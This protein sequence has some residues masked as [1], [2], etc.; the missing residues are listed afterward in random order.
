MNRRR[1]L[2]LTAGGV[3][4]AACGGGSTDQEFA[5][6]KWFSDQTILA[7]GSPQR[8][9]WSFRDDE[10]N[11]ADQA[12]PTAEYVVLGP[13][14]DQIAS[15]TT[16][17][18]DDGVA[19]PYYPVMIAFSEPGIHEFRF[20][21]DDHGRHVGFASPGLAAD[22]TLFWPGDAFPSVPT[23][24][25]DDD[26]G[27]ADICTRTENCPFHDVSLDAALRSGRPT[28]LLVS[29]PAFCGTVWMCGP[30]LEL[31]IEEV[32]ASPLDA[33]IIHAEVYVDPQPDDL[34]EL[35]PVVVASGAGYE[36]FAFAFDGD[37]RVVGRLDHT[38]DR[39]ELRALLDSI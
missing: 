31:L 9:I 19:L 36:P 37:G 14:G 12:P 20:T 32:A 21:T 34:G 30:V 3:A 18:H 25:T 27:V 35:L 17:R 38:F 24:T 7:D 4:L 28:V 33:N 11:L 1:F 39:S 26:Q 5:T 6:E 15:G 13:D 22:S 29:T 10:G 8:T 2:G 16:E 23:P